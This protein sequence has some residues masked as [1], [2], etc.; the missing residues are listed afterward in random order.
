MSVQKAASTLHNMNR[1]LFILAASGA[2]MALPQHF[3]A[4]CCC[5]TCSCSLR[6]STLQYCEWQQ[7]GQ[8]EA[9]NNTTP[10][11]ADFPHQQ[12]TTPILPMHSAAQQTT[13]ARIAGMAAHEHKSSHPHLQNSLLRK[14]AYAHNRRRSQHLKYV[15]K[16]WQVLVPVNCWS[17]FPGD[18]EE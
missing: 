16:C 6:C 3:A 12:P 15:A 1:P 11:T 2:T 8:Y 9:H 7:Q 10:P 13:A 17:P 18:A 5:C 14:P 4:S